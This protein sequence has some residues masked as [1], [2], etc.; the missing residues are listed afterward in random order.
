MSASHSE[1]HP[2][3][4]IEA[5]A[6]GL[7]LIAAADASIED[8]VLNG[9]NGWAIEDDTRLWEKAVELLADKESRERMGRRSVEISRNY[10]VGRFVDSSLEVY[11]TYRKCPPLPSPAR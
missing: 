11:E 4:F 6:S 3:T 9:E 1:V 8:M 5:M 2:I 10:S 7:P